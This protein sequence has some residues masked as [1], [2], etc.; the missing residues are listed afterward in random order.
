MNF[1]FD[2]KNNFFMNIGQ[3]SRQP[4]H[5]NIYL[6]FRNDIDPGTMNEEISGLEFG[7]A[8]RGEKFAANVNLYS[9]VWKNRVFRNTFYNRTI[10]SL[11]SYLFKNITQIHQGI[12]VD[13]TYR[14]I[15][16][17]QVKGYASFGNWNYGKGG[18]ITAFD[19]DLNV[20]NSTLNLPTTI[21]IEGF[22]VGDAAQTTFGLGTSYKFLDGFKVD[23]DWNYFANLYSNFVP[24][25]NNTGAIE[26]P[27]YDLF[28]LG[29]SYKWNL[30]EKSSLLFRGNINNLF[31]E[32]Y[33]SDSRN[34]S[35]INI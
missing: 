29:L 21:N 25:T 20:V 1:K 22:K 13:F 6:N 12:E 8:Y 33:I 17:L 4:F 19:E 31:D 3:Y 26:L 35:S 28:D 11:T 7:Y 16:D 30:N 2:E 10:R 15:T 34:L 27:D 18:T 9:T 14:P 23:A 24:N 5:D 32:V